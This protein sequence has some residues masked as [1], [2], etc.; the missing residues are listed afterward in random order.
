MQPR[1][2]GKADHLWPTRSGFSAGTQL[3]YLSQNLWPGRTLLREA[4]L[5]HHLWTP[6]KCQPC[7]RWE[8]HFSHTKTGDNYL[9]FM[10]TPPNQVLVPPSETTLILWH[11]NKAQIVGRCQQRMQNGG[12][13][14]RAKYAVSFRSTEVFGHLTIE[15]S[16][17]IPRRQNEL[18]S[19]V[20]IVN[21]ACVGAE[22]IDI[23]S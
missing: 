22:R 7:S 4:T 3:F 20:C 9:W 1:L 12:C 6:A 5:N 17:R 2:S 11:S 8:T 10:T 16:K 14:Q 15:L 19:P 23:Y 13:K 21:T 18:F